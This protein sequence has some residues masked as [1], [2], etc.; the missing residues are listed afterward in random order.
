[1]A[2]GVTYSW[3]LTVLLGLGIPVPRP[4]RE[5]LLCSKTSVDEAAYVTSAYT[6]KL[7]SHWSR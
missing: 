3:D 5:K 6:G 4:L 1:M 2:R 7:L